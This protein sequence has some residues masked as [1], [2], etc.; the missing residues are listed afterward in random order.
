MPQQPKDDWQ[1]VSDWEDIPTDETPRGASPGFLASVSDYIPSPV[2]S[3]W[4][5]ANIS[6]FDF[7]PS[8]VD[9]SNIARRATSYFD[10]E[11]RDPYYASTATRFAGD[12]LRGLPTPLNVATAGSFGAAAKA[13]KYGMPAASRGLQAIGG[14][15]SVPVTAE[16]AYNVAAGETLPEKVLGGLELA[17]GAVGMRAGGRALRG[18]FRTP[19]SKVTT[20]EANEIPTTGKSKI[21]AEGM[22]EPTRVQ[23]AETVKTPAKPSEPPVTSEELQTSFMKR[24]MT[25][26]E[27]AL[28]EEVLFGVTGKQQ[29]PIL[30][31]IHNPTVAQY[32]REVREDVDAIGGGFAEH[33]R[34]REA[35]ELPQQQADILNKF[36]IEPKTIPGKETFY[37][38]EDAP[39]PPWHTTMSDESLTNW[40]QR[41]AD[42]M[43]RGVKPSMLPEGATPLIGEKIT[44]ARPKV[45]EQRVVFDRDGN[46]RVLTAEEADEFVAE[47]GETYGIMKSNG[48]FIKLNDLGGKVPDDVKIIRPRR[49]EYPG[50]QEST[51]KTS[52]GDPNLQSTLR[53]RL[54]AET[55]V[56]NTLQ[57]EIPASLS[58]LNNAISEGHIPPGDQGMIRRALAL[59]KGFLTSWD[60][61]APGRQGKSFI[62]NKEWWTSLDDMIKAWGSER[63]ANLVYDAIENHPSGY[64]RHGVSEAG[65]R[66]PSFAEKMGLDLAEHEEVFSNRIDDAIQH[67]AGI[68]MASR[69]HTAFLNKLRS[70]IFARFMENSKKLGKNPE[71]ITEIARAYAKFINDA[72]GRGSLN[73]GKW[74][75]ERNAQ[76]LNDVFFAPK[77]MSGQIR[78]WN[79]VLNPVAYYNYDPVLRK[80]ALRSLFAI[81][82]TGLMMGEV[83]RIAGARVVNDPTSSDFRKIIIG[84]THID[85]FGGYQQFPV[86]AMKFLSG[87]QT[88]TTPYGK[89]GRETNLD[90]GRYGQ[91]S[92][93]TVAERYFINR[94]SPAAS[95]V[96]AW[97]FNK[98]FDGK[99]FEYKKAL[100]NRTFPI[101]AQDLFQLAQE[102]PALGLAMTP[103]NM[104]G[105]TGTQTYSRE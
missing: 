30:P 77:N 9:P 25:P 88:A 75:L 61:S 82:G 47:P 100:F 78:T 26:E 28:E 59:N 32:L 36:G 56:K 21:P 89:P 105:L 10:P 40:K 69:A 90:A 44:G 58:E 19:K 24:E 102:D 64:F 98:D 37:L 63:G 84:R 67:Y 91:A 104:M 94:L 16:G 14:A 60:F 29:A 22:P 73:F 86:A 5:A 97:M 92:R 45:V 103:T 51:D 68:R 2:K 3:A 81:A 83:A 93:G 87:Q 96:Y 8:A 7:L 54:D 4:R 50:L 31:H 79:S 46:Q 55:V 6:A 70:D 23:S 15:L 27:L 20:F 38:P 57:E 12:I 99:P 95:F 76:V 74:K 11:E 65:K 62:L 1:D 72:T 39:L 18:G 85:P 34:M 80:Q 52:K 71:E 42:D 41:W 53:D 33:R 13:A 35:P 43:N 49:R 101:A 66:L 17:G 48:T